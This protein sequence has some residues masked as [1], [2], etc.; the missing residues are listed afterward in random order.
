M[1]PTK[2]FLTLSLVALTLTSCGGTDEVTGPA[3]QETVEQPTPQQ[4]EDLT[5]EL[6]ARRDAMLDESETVGQGTFRVHTMSGAELEFDLPTS[7]DHE[8]LQ[9]ITQYMEDVN[10]EPATFIVVDVDN[11]QGQ[12]TVGLPLIGVFDPEGNEYEF[13]SVS[14]YISEIEPERDWEDDAQQTLNDGTPISNEEHFDLSSR[15]T[16][17]HNEYLHGIKA[18]GRGNQILVYEG[19]DLPSEFTRVA[20]WPLG[21]GEAEDAYLLD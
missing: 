9:D 14:Q 15:G 10:A 3:P 16:E 2:L 13:T 11:R 8:A 6:E 18:A 1:K 4:T 17:L 21:L 12:E 19:D 5:P 7:P 20:T